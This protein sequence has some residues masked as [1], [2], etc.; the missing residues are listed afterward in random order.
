MKKVSLLACLFLAL[1]LTARANLVDEEKEIYIGR[2]LITE[3]AWAQTGAYLKSF[4][5]DLPNAVSMPSPQVGFVFTPG[6]TWSVFDILELNVGFPLVLNPDETGDREVDAA[7]SNPQLKQR[8]DWDDN[9]DFDLPGL[10]VG[11]KGSLLGK[12]AKDKVFL[13]VGVTASLPIFE[14][15]ATNFHV[16]KTAPNH[17]SP[18]MVSPYLSLGYTTGR[19]SPQFQMGVNF[20]F[21]R[22]TG[23]DGM[24]ITD[25]DD[26]IETQRYTDFFFNL[27]LPFAFP[28][29]G[30]VPM[31]EV[32]GVYNF[33]DETAQ[34]F[35]TPA[36]TF[37]PKGSPAWLGFAC[38]IPILDSDWRDKEGFRFMVNFSYKFDFLAV[39]ALG[40]DEDSGGATDE[41]PPAGW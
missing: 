1:P 33:D 14:E 40:D 41:S 29:E 30:T 27:A 15:W 34:I 7:E 25:D 8:D 18:F 6:F 24:Y 39:P 10:I 3:P 16:W 13:A 5:F 2:P 32:N 23:L 21:D 31:L 12:K 9:P 28:F 38:M 35:I 17:T 37:L 36:V 26:N 19:F 11:L 4:M 20:R 22:M